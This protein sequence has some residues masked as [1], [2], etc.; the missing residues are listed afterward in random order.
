MLWVFFP[1]NVVAYY[2]FHPSQHPWEGNLKFKQWS[3]TP[4]PTTSSSNIEGKLG[5]NTQYKKT[6]SRSTWKCNALWRGGLGYSEA[7]NIETDIPQVIKGG[8]KNNT[9]V[10]VD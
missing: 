10:L 4:K 5:Y 6:T 8:Q 2:V 3:I 7:T 9:Q 1:T